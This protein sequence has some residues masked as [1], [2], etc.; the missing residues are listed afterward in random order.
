[1]PKSKP[2]DAN[3]TGV[4]NEQINPNTQGLPERLRAVGQNPYE[5]FELAYGYGG[6]S[7]QTPQLGEVNLPNSAPQTFRTDGYKG[8]KSAPG[9]TGSG[10]E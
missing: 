1:M 10:G 3:S 7:P 8:G 6:E 9:R 2:A 4:Y 5:G